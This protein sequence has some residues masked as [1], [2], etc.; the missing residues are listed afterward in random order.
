[1][2]IPAQRTLPK[3]GEVHLWWGHLPAGEDDALPASLSEEERARWQAFRTPLLRRRYACRRA[4]VRAVLGEALALD[5]ALLRFAAGEH[6]KPRLDPAQAAGLSFNLS[7]TGDWVLLGVAR[8]GELGVDVETLARRGSLE[9]VAQRVFCDAELARLGGRA[10][11]AAW[12]A[13]FLRGWTRKEALLKALGTGL[14][15]DPREVQ[16]GLDEPPAGRPWPL[17]DPALGSWGLD[18]L[19]APPGHA[20][21]ACAP[22]SAWRS[23][24]RRGWREA[25][26]AAA[27]RP[28]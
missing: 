8:G 7:H 10:E 1:M 17:P 28:A 4:L 5:P 25:L 16:V 12:E 15:R 3:P 18:D 13:A 27:P 11:P 26:P 6:G 23:V 21:A 24:V 20:A 22:G 9:G 2:G 19:D 14:L